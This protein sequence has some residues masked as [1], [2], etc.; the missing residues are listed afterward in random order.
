MY[1]SS[2]PPGQR[3]RFGHLKVYGEN[4][5]VEFDPATDRY[6]TDLHESLPMLADAL[7]PSIGRSPGAGGVI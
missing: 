6:V 4:P 7:T 3:H 5:V 1:N 2:A